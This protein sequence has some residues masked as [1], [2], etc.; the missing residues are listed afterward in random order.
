MA[1]AVVVGHPFRPLIGT[2]PIVV[3]NPSC[4]PGHPSTFDPP[5]LPP[6]VNAWHV[7]RCLL[8]LPNPANN[9]LYPSQPQRKWTE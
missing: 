7:H 4:L 6:S 2:F 5:M 3:E 8:H 9:H 1:V